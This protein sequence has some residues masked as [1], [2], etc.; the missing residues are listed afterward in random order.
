MSF[1][2][3]RRGLITTLLLLTPSGVASAD[4]LSEVSE[5]LRTDAQAQSALSIC[6]VAAGEEA[7]V[8]KNKVSNDTTVCSGEPHA[9]LLDCRAG[10]PDRC[11]Q[12][13]LVLEG[14]KGQIDDAI[15]GAQS[16]YALGCRT[17]DAASCTN[18]A[19][20]I[21]HH[22]LGIPTSM[23]ERI[24]IDQADWSTCLLRTFSATCAV[25]N[26]WGCTM[27]GLMLSNDALAG[28]HPVK[29]IAAFDR[30]CELAPRSQPCQMGDSIREAAGMPPR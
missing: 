30:A 6:P 23:S 3:F 26:V 12:L 13:A 28:T 4:G 5:L 1:R 17:G 29:A 7:R 21:M 18:R 11:F 2:A 24:D 8:T 25:D 19:A 22:R 10:D 15:V 27:K 20:G 9:C 14:K 16:L